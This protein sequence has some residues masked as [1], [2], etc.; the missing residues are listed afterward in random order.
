[1][2]VVALRDDADIIVRDPGLFEIPH[3]AFCV[4]EGIE[5]TAK[6]SGHET[7]SCC[8]GWAQADLS[9]PGLAIIRIA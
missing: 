7:L 4:T 2:V 1:M 3:G 5:K 9:G 8:G 6:G